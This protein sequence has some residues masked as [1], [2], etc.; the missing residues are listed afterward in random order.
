MNE[1]ELFFSGDQLWFSYKQNKIDYSDS[2][3]EIMGAKK[4]N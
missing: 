2:T 4:V 3:K 1:F